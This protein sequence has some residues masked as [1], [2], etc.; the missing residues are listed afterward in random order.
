MAG[1]VRWPDHRIE[2]VQHRTLWT[3][4]AAQGL[5]GLGITI[6]IAVTALLAEQIS[7]TARPTGVVV[8]RGVGMRNKPLAR[9]VSPGR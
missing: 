7:K 9:I 1:G 4:V 2:Q 5:G 8:P 3:L 6:G